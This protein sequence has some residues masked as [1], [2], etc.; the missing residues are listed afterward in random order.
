VLLVT[1]QT[2]QP[3]KKISLE[4]YK[5]TKG[6]WEEAVQTQAVQLLAVQQQQQVVALVGKAN[7]VRQLL[8][9]QTSSSSSSKKQCSCRRM[10]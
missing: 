2:Q 8:V 10:L 5:S 7:A 4:Q 6:Y 9:Q 3:A 1:H